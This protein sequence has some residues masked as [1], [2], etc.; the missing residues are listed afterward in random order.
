MISLIGDALIIAGVWAL[1]GQ[2]PKMDTMPLA[3]YTKLQSL[4]P[5]FALLLPIG[6]ILALTGR[7]LCI[8]DAKHKVRA[9]FSALFLVGRL[10]FLEG[11]ACM[12]AFALLY[13]ELTPSEMT[14]M[15]IWIAATLGIGISCMLIARKIGATNS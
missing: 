5:L 10:P 11:V 2:Y 6:I 14:N 9:F 3:L 12:G 4:N 13:N 8:I 7:I 1:M 15:L